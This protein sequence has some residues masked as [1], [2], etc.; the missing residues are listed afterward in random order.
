MGIPVIRDMLANTVLAHV[1]HNHFN[2]KMKV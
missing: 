1:P 2:F